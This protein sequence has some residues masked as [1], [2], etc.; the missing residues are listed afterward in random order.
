M[1][2]IVVVVVVVVEVKLKL[3]SVTFWGDPPV[4]SITVHYTTTQQ[5]QQQ[6]YRISTIIHIL[7][8]IQSVHYAII[9]NWPEQHQLVALPTRTGS[10]EKSLLCSMESTE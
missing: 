4:G 6:Q 2:A 10:G 7:Y 3:V 1:I 9:L 5:Q 8:T